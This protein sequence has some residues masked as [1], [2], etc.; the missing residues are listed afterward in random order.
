MDLLQCDK[1]RSPLTPAKTTSRN[2][3]TTPQRH[4]RLSSISSIKPVSQSKSSPSSNKKTKSPKVSKPDDFEIIENYINDHYGKDDSLDNK[5]NTQHNHDLINSNERKYSDDFST[6]DPLLI[7]ENDNL[8]IPDNL[9][10][11]SYSPNEVDVYSIQYDKKISATEPLTFPK[12]DLQH[13]QNIDD[14]DFDELMSALNDDCD[15]MLLVLDTKTELSCSTGMNKSPGV[16]SKKLTSI[17]RSVSLTNPVKKARSMKTKQDIHEYLHGTTTAGSLFPHDHDIY[18]EY[19]KY[20]Q[21]YL[22]DKAAGTF[23]MDNSPSPIS[24]A[25]FTVKPSGDS[26]YGR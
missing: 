10:I 21:E 15:E 16:E 8:T 5:L 6:I 1:P 24:A 9:I 22:K 26:A 25:T 13:S 12:I 18:E 19:K 4:V 3:T 7:N 23:P 17:K 2:K 20:E 11:E 14:I